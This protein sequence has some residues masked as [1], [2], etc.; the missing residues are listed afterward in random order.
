[1]FFGGGTPSLFSPASIGSLLETLDQHFGLDADCEITLEANPDEL[2]DGSPY[3]SRLRR[4]GVTR[5]SIGVQSFNADVLATLGRSHD[6]RS[7]DAAIHAAIGADFTSVS[8]DLIFAVPGQSSE[9]WQ[10]DLEQATAAGFDHVSTYNLTYEQGTPLT[11]LRDVGRIQPLDDSVER[12]LY[13]QALSHFGDLGFE[14]YEVSS[15]AKP[16]KRC[17][18]NQSYWQWKNFLGLGAGAH[19]F[20]RTESGTFGQRY[21]NLRQPSAYMGAA[22]GEHAAWV[23]T[24]D[25]DAAVKELILTGLR[26]I[27]G[28]ELRLLQ[29]VLGPHALA[30]YPRLQQLESAGLLDTTDTHIRLTAEGVLVADSVIETLVLG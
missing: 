10:R 8:C 25:R 21:E 28:I 13:R 14:Q 22:P 17:R 16:G 29:N 26:Q 20:M 4:A 6:A 11:G 27:E 5:L 1:V 12:S 3:T 30:E 9:L 19:G 23:E 24:I 2:A 18:H 15:F 7:I